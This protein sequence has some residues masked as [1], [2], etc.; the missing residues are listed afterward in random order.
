MHI[1]CEPIC[2]PSCWAS[3]KEDLRKLEALHWI[4]MD[5]QCYFAIM[6]FRSI[7]TFSACSLQWAPGWL[8]SA[9]LSP[10]SS[11]LDA[12]AGDPTS[13][14]CSVSYAVKIS[15]S[16]ACLIAL[17]NDEHVQLKNHSPRGVSIARNA[18][19]ARNAQNWIPV[20]LGIHLTLKNVRFPD[21]D[22]PCKSLVVPCPRVFSCTPQSWVN[23]W[24]PQRRA[25]GAAALLVEQSAISKS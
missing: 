17:Q 3:L 15:Y 24:Q 9:S 22:W 23:S 11:A 25:R 19:N 10:W 6:L 2:C 4:C 8:C 7:L 1:F 16:I 14:A 13:G 5:L 12:W 21:I 18:R 20:A